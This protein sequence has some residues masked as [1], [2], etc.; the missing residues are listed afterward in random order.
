M[1]KIKIFK[2]VEAEGTFYSAYFNTD[3]LIG[4]VKLND[5]EKETEDQAITRLKTKLYYDNLTG[6]ALEDKFFE[7]K[8][9]V[10]IINLS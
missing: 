2:E 4:L 9:L 1:P 6:V 5:Y 3:H 7:N 10:S 8:K